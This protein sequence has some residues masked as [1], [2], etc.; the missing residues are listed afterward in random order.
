MFRSALSRDWFG[1]MWGMEPRRE[2]VE[3]RINLE[4]MHNFKLEATECR[5]EKQEWQC[6]CKCSCR[7]RR[8]TQL[9]LTLI[10]FWKVKRGKLARLHKW[11]HT[12]ERKWQIWRLRGSDTW[13]LR[14]WLLWADRRKGRH[15]SR[16]SWEERQLIYGF[17]LTLSC[18][19]GIWRHRPRSIWE[20]VMEAWKRKRRGDGNLGSTSVELRS[21]AL[22]VCNSVNLEI[23]D[24]EKRSKT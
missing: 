15:R 18:W 24:K 19:Q 7:G 16:L 12:V 14:E 11:F 4:S 22:W 17:E 9:P 13:K 21:E 2:K 8:L 1:S 3:A 20:Y 6:W 10:H 5:D 23:R